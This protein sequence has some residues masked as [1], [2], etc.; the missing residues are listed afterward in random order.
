MSM[1]FAATLAND[2]A[3]V[4]A[5][6]PLFKTSIL[7]V[8]QHTASSSQSQINL[9]RDAKITAVSG[10]VNNNERAALLMDGD[11]NTKWCDAQAAPNYV[12]F[13]FGQPTTISRWRL[14]SA[15]CEQSAYIT[16]TCLLQG[17]NSETEEWHTLDMFDGNRNNYTDR[18]FASA[19]VR[20]LRL[21][22]VAPTQGQ[23][24][25]A[26]IYELEVY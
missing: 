7:P 8:A 2:E 19:T 17:R 4:I 3:D 20:Y 13:D 9:L 1:W 23:D 18:N 22:V 26:R 14:L 12:A 16:R 25:A 11:P 21:F 5:A 15:A 10:E 6:S 24:S